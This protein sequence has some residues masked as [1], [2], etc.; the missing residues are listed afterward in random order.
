MFRSFL[1]E[2]IKDNWK[3]QEGQTMA[4]YGIILGLITLGVIALLVT[5][6]GQ[7][8]SKFQGVVDALTGH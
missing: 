8:Q 5:L 3:R 4:E 6:G 7:I 1:A 2:W